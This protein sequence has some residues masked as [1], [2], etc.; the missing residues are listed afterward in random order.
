MVTLSQ[1]PPVAATLPIRYL[2]RFSQIPSWAR[3]VALGLLLSPLFPASHP[4]AQ[5]PR[6]AGDLPIEIPIARCDGLPVIPVRIG[7]AEM[8]F[9]MDTA[10][11]SFL[12]LKS[13]P[14]GRARQIH[15]R[16]WNG[17]SS[18][19]A[20]E[21]SLP[22]I[23]LGN[24][25]LQDLKLPAIDLSPLEQSSGCR[26]DGILG[27][28][29][30]DSFGV[31]I[32]LKRQVA[33]LDAMPATWPAAGLSGIEAKSV[34]IADAMHYCKIDLILGNKDFF[35]ECLDPEIVFATSRGKFR[36]RKKV[37]DYLMQRYL[38]FATTVRYEINLQDLQ[39]ADDTIRYSFKYSADSSNERSAGAGTAICRRSGGRWRIVYIQDSSIGA[40]PGN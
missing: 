12:N 39:S 14:S 40:V 30:L 13:F 15:V 38:K 6:P 2:T 4:F 37:T 11:N 8:R 35:K 17:P 20:R 10:A 24:R 27:V 28:E 32:N 3:T 16:A 31:T 36:G 22:E 25:R 7:N 33:V 34:E 19:N 21:I 29:L 18:A 5:N 9:L 26:I 1:L 23:E